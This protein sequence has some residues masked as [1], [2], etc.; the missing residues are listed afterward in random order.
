MSVSGCN[1]SELSFHK[2]MD[3]RGYITMAWVGAFGFYC[4]EER[5]DIFILYIHTSGLCILYVTSHFVLEN[6]YKMITG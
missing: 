2:R 6:E 4:A 3:S 5:R 1:C